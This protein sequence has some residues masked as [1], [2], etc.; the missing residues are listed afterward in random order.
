MD[1]NKL[2]V[3]NDCG[4]SIS[5]CCNFCTYGRFRI[6]SDFGTCAKKTYSHEKHTESFR[7]LSINKYGLCE[8]SFVLDTGK[9]WILEAYSQFFKELK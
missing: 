4:Y 5:E 7:D 8:D 1:K 2:K 9:Y 6:T 3:L